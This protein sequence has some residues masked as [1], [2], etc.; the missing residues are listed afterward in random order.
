MKKSLSRASLMLCFLALIYLCCIR[1]YVHTALYFWRAFFH[2]SPVKSKALSV[3]NSAFYLSTGVVFY[4][5]IHLS[6]LSADDKMHI[7]IIALSCEHILSRSLPLY[8]P[9]VPVKI[10]L[11]LMSLF[12][13]PVPSL[14]SVADSFFFESIFTHT[15]NTKSTAHKPSTDMQWAFQHKKQYA[16]SCAKAEA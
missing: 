16:Q 7:Y 6:R 1:H 4:S 15:D 14:T 9:Q 13:K 11:R 5:D 8:S 12:F 3:R 10:N 2:V